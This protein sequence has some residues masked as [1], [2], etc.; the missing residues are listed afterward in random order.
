MLSLRFTKAAATNDPQI[1][2]WRV[3][4]RFHV[5]SIEIVRRIASAGRVM[6]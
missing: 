6:H 2:D 5:A 4:V 3:E 1:S